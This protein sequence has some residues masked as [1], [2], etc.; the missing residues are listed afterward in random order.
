MCHWSNWQ[1]ICEGRYDILLALL[2]GAAL[3]GALMLIVLTFAGA[4]FEV[5]GG[6]YMG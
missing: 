6:Q 3:L 4:T 2:I 5:N 1:F